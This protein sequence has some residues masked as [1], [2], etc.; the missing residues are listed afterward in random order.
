MFLRALI[1]VVSSCSQA[2]IKTCF[3]CAKNSKQLKGFW[4]ETKSRGDG[5]SSHF[6]SY[7]LVT[8]NDRLKINNE[9]WK[10]R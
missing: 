7:T 9:R 5:E 10:S 8:L 6:Y 1:C 4:R 2:K 3:L